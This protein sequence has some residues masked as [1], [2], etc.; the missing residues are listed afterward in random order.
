MNPYLR[1]HDSST[2]ALEKGLDILELFAS[3]QSGLTVTEAARALNRTVS[4]IFRMLACLKQRGYLFQ[5]ENRGKYHLTLRIFSLAQE[6]PPPNRLIT[7]SLPVMH[8][9]AH[10]LR[11][12]CHLEVLDGGYVVIVAQV[13][14]SEST[15]FH[16]KIG[17]KME[18]MQSATGHVILAYQR[19]DLRRHA[20]EEWARETQR[21]KPAELDARLAKVRR[22]GHETRASLQV[23][24]V[25]NVSFPVFAASGEV[26][27]CLTVPYVKRLED[28]VDVS[29][30]VRALRLASSELS[31]ALGANPVH[32]LP[33]PVRAR[34]KIPAGDTQDLRHQ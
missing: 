29:D 21:K 12:S 31:E 32:S 14:A 17:S 1:R 16:V 20:L 25:V 13:D 18:L 33:G 24:G 27:A 23:K 10:E 7:E 5:L 26:V 3:S 19:E 11:Q 2:P 28:K 8:G 15:G 6:H 9:V 34:S 4:E 22:R 30:V